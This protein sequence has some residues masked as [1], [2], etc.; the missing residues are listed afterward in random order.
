MTSYDFIFYA[1]SGIIIGSSVVCVFHP[2]ILYAGLSLFGAFFG[3]AGIYLLLGADFLAATQ[4]L[5]YVGGI[6]TLLLFAVMLSKNIYGVKFEE[7]KKRKIAPTLFC[8]ILLGFLIKFIF[9]AHWNI[10]TPS[11]PPAAT[12][13]RLGTLLLTDYLLL[14]E[15]S[16]VLLLAALIGA[17]VLA[18]SKS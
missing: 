10:V 16:S 11:E 3:V 2:N 4:V 12:T 13:H 5:I 7:E 18:R 8:M 1:F 14:F 9:S 15:L 17:I 6:L